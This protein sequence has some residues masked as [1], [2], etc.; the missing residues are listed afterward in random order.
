M[1]SFLSERAIISFREGYYELYVYTDLCVYIVF[2]PR[3]LRKLVLNGSVI[4]VLPELHSIPGQGPH[5]V[6]GTF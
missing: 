5:D 4:F 1:Y 3:G 6:N 2:F